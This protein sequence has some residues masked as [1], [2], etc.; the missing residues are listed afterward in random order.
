MNT[1]SLP[2]GAR[3][4]PVVRRWAHGAL[5]ALGLLLACSQSE[6]PA[7][8]PAPQA[9]QIVYTT[10]GEITVDGETLDHDIVIADGIVTKRDKGPSRPRRPEFNHTPLTPDEAIPWDCEV[11]VIGTGMHERLPV[12][13]ELVAEAQHRGVELVVMPTVDAVAYY[14]E[15]ERPGMNA[16]FHVTC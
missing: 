16:V 2:C 3:L 10:F 5:M 14:N 13:P 1:H 9:P 11:L 12:V 8:P 4:E 7:T 15:H 6:A